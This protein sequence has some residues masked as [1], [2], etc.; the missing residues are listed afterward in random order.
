[1]VQLQ[2]VS[3]NSACH[4]PGPTGA[5]HPASQVQSE[6]EHHSFWTNFTQYVSDENPLLPSCFKA[7]LSVTESWRQHGN[8]GGYYPFFFTN[9]VTSQSGGGRGAVVDCKTII[10]AID[11]SLTSSNTDLYTVVYDPDMHLQPQDVPISKVV[12]ANMFTSRLGTIVPLQG[13]RTHRN[14]AQ[15]TSLRDLP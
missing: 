7:V 10:S 3:Y 12:F 14:H 1:M 9:T 11:T 15:A 6:P 8:L 5:N 2:P 4:Q 13:P